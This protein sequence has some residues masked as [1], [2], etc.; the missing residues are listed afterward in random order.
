MKLKLCCRFFLLTVFLCFT[1]FSSAQTNTTLAPEDYLAMKD[2]NRALA[3]FLKMYKTNSADI[4]INYYIGYCYLNVNDDRSKAIPYLLSA[5]HNK[6]DYEDVQLLLG[7][8]YMYHYEFDEAIKYFT[9][10]RATVSSKNYE[11][12]DHYIEDCQSAKILVKNPLNVTFENLGKEVNSKFPDYYPFI[13]QDEGTLYFTSRREGGTS[14]AR[15]WGG[16]S[17]ADVYFSKPHAGQWQKA[18]S[19]G[20]AINTAGD[21]ECVD[22]TS[23]GKNMILFIDN[24]IFIGDIYYSSMGKG[25]SFP[26]PSEFDEPV[27]S[28][29]VEYEGCITQDGSM[30]IISS[31]RKGGLGGNDLWVI[32]KLPTG[33]WGMPMNAGENVNTK[34]DEAFPVFDE[35]NNI[36]YFASQGHVNMG[37]F[38]IFKSKYDP[39]THTFGPAENIGYPIN[40]PEDNMEFT[41]AEN[42]RDGY[43]SAV[44]PEGFGDLD[45]YRVVFNSVDARL[46]VIHG[47][48][49][50]IDS[51]PLSDETYVVLE[52]AITKERIDSSLVNTVSGKYILAVAAGKYL[53]YVSSGGYDDFSLAVNV[54]DKSEYQFEF[55]KNIVLQKKGAQ[56]P[57]AKPPAPAPKKIPNAPVKK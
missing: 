35:Q 25:K 24:D 21:E 19:I 36:L 13:T 50:K 57:P 40:T 39:L 9:A 10:Y 52:N 43:V 22:V 7:E 26:K 44:R 33:D 14:R 53:L 56:A 54:F 27:N 41:L 45:I 55:D 30:I 28:E 49:S 42:H 16:Y 47:T 48:V 3:G 20:P 11:K 5:Y 31:S 46:S 23:D 12:I 17:T 37:G 4:S 29:D 6:K 38:D 1:F 2:Y 51:L 18:K 8:A 32:K 15:S 34:Y